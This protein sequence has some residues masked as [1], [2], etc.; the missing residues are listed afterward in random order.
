MKASSLRVWILSLGSLGVEKK[1]QV[2]SKGVA[3][4]RYGFLKETHKEPGIT[5]GICLAQGQDHFP[6]ISFPVF[7][8]E[9]TRCGLLQA[10]QSLG[11]PVLSDL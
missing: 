4:M 7:G 10:P 6:S 9:R 5:V 2:L 1:L 11:S 8:T 3:M